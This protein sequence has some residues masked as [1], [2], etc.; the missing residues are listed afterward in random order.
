MV[1]T[2]QGARGFKVFPISFPSMDKLAA[3]IEDELTRQ[4]H[5]RTVTP[6]AEPWSWRVGDAGSAYLKGSED[7]P[8]LVAQRPAGPPFPEPFRPDDPGEIERVVEDVL[9]TLS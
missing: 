8:S 9:R 6:N 3:R 1:E 4:A 7:E 2:M 5:P